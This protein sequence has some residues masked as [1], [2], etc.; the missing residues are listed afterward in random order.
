M[1]SYS[2]SKAIA[3]TT[4]PAFAQWERLDGKNE[5][6]SIEIHGEQQLVECRR[7]FESFGLTTIMGG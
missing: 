4:A 2:T 3:S 7:I 1:E 5:T 6:A